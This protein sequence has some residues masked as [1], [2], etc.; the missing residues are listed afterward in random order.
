[1]RAVALL[2]V[3]AVVPLSCGHAEAGRPPSLPGTL[4]AASSSHVVTIVMENKEYG[5]SSA[6]ATPPA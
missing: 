4:P 1:M 6:P 5:R 2:A 3:L